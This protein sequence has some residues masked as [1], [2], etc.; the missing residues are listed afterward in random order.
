[1]KP[2]LKQIEINIGVDTGAKQLDIYIRPLNIYFSVDNDEKGIKHAIKDIKKHKPTRVIIEA[3]GRLEQAFVIACDKAELPYVVANP[4]HIRKFAGAIGQL[5]KTDKLDAQLIAHYGDKLKPELTKIKPKLIREI[6]DVVTRRNQ[7]TKLQSM[8]KNRLSRMPKILAKSYQNVLK[9][10]ADEIKIMD[11]W[12]D[13]L[14]EN[15]P[16]YQAKKTLLQ[17]VPGIGKVASTTLL[18]YLPELGTLNAKQVAALVGVAPINKE[19]GLYKGQRKIAKGRHQVRT[20]LYMAIMSAIQC[21]PVIIE[22]YQRLLKRGKIKKVALIACV[23]KM[24]IIL[25]SMIRDNKP[26]EVNY[27]DKFSS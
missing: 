12:L 9:T 1:M 8:E 22:T 2:Q 13:N 4:I 7:L 11:E 27:S 15:N 19:S 26:W 16:Q 3:T 10:L 23:R 25:N 14:I 17:S 6:G 5:A 21:N 20:A 24:L 18:S